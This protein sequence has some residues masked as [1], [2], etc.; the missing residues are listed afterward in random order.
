M[1]KLIENLKYDALIVQQILTL[2]LACSHNHTFLQR[3]EKSW[4]FFMTPA[5]KNHDPLWITCHISRMFF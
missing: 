3:E 4:I 2:R 1:A 5:F